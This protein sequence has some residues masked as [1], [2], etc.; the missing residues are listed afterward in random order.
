MGGRGASSGISVSG[1]KYGTEY[2]TVLQSGNIKFVKYNDAKTAKTPME[3]MTRGRIY[4]TVTAQDK[5]KAITFYDKSGKR[6]SQIDL[7]GHTHTVDGKR[8]IP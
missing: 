8:S 1:K 7:G 6:S 5:L 3:T 4:V 2:R